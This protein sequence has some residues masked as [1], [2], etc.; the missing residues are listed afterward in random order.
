MIVK[1]EIIVIKLKLTRI[2]ICL[3]FYKYS[4]KNKWE[5]ICYYCPIIRYAARL[6]N[7]IY[8]AIF[9][10]PRSCFLLNLRFPFRWLNDPQFVGSF[11]TEDHV[12][13]LFR[14]SAVEY[15]NCG[16]VKSVPWTESKSGV[17]CFPSLEDTRGAV[18]R[19][20]LAISSPLTCVRRI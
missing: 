16:K 3:N 2:L 4:I 6:F 12:Y 17:T 7:L 5:I 15:I 14:E 10:I 20:R 19:A 1:H 8:R 18:S 13:F 9:I 11:E